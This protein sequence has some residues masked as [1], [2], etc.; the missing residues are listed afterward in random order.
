MSYL[1]DPRVFFAAERTLLAWMRTGIALLGLGFVVERF[2]LFVRLM[3][4]GRELPASQQLAS[5][6]LAVILLSIGATV[7]IV[8]ARQFTKFIM[9]L[10][11]AEVPRG[12]P[13]WLAPAV[14]YA[15]GCV[16]LGM[17]A[18]MVIAH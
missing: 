5:L 16:S 10:S 14:N 6:V 15:L 1:D 18:W 8:A 2:G 7:M 3:A 13:V 4:G 17:I 9:T 12:H 11:P